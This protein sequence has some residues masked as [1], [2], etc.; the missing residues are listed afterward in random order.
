MAIVKV[1]AF[2][3]SLDGFGAGPNQDVHNPLGVRGME[4]PRWFFK[5]KAFKKNHGGQGGEEGVDNDLAQ[6]AM[7]NIGAWILGRNMFGPIRGPWPDGSWKGWWGE[8]PP[9][10]CDVFVLTHH[11]R[12]SIPMQGGTVFHFVTEGI[13]AALQKAKKAAKDKDVRIGGGVST[14][15]QYLREGLI[16]EM[17]L[18]YSPVYLGVGENLLLDINLNDLGFNHVEHVSGENA[19][20]VLLKKVKSD[21][22]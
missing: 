22:K 4:L 5:T 16:D 8:E 21:P 12:A 9:Y 18:A 3:V 1:A 20:H 17:H 10:H 13:H 11:S 7:E 19:L 6:K 15:R 2:T 14:I